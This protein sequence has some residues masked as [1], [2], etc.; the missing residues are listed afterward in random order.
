EVMN[1]FPIRFSSY[2]GL[3]YPSL[4]SSSP[5][6]TRNT[7]PSGWRTCI[8]RTFQGMSVGGNVTSRP[9]ATHC[10]CT[11]STSSTQTDIHTPLSHS[12]SPSLVKVEAFVPRPRPPCPPWQRKI[13][14]SPDPTAPKVG[15][16]PQ[17]QHLRQ[18]H[19]W[20][21][22]KLS[23]ESPCAKYQASEAVSET[24]AS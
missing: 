1:C 21:P 2:A 3:V 22:A 19:F 12:S 9:A 16:V 7:W 18:P 14:H 15:G 17:S 13:S 23:W 5:L 6:L 8:S 10:L 11:A 4:A 20:N 24:A